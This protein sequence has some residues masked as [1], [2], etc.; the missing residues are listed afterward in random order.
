MMI[1]ARKRR[2]SS[3]VGRIQGFVG[4][5]HEYRTSVAASAVFAFLYGYLEYY[6]IL[7]SRPG[8]PFRYAYTPIF[9]GFYW[10]HIFPMLPI[11]GLIGFLPLLDDILFKFKPRQVEKLRTGILGLVNL[12]LAVWFEDMFWFTFRLVDPLTG[13]PLGGKWIQVVGVGGLPDWTAR[14]GYFDFGGNALPYWY[15]ISALLLAV[16]YYVVFFRPQLLERIRAY[17]VGGYE[18]RSQGKA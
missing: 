5:D 15:V 14:W 17:F 12:W 1:P 8:L 11:F 10:Y 16:A 7:Q 9:L 3:W 13:D 4:P 6:Y 2:R 18:R